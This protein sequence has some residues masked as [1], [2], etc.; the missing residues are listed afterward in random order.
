MSSLRPLLS[1]SFG[2]DARSLALLRMTAGVLF[3]LVRLVNLPQAVRLFSDHGCLTRA[4]LWAAGGHYSESFSLFL[5][6]GHPTGILLLYAF[7][8]VCGVALTVGYHTRWATF[9]CWFCDMSLYHRNPYIN[10]ASDNELQL[11]LLWGFF[12]P[13]GQLWS[14]DAR[15]STPPES[16]KPYLQ[17][18]TAAWRLQ[19]MA[20]YMGAALIKNTHHW[21]DGSAVEISLQSDFWSSYLGN[22]LCDWALGF[23]GLLSSVTESVLWIEFF[24]PLLIIAPLWQLQ[25][26]ALLSLAAMHILFGLCLNLETFSTVACSLMVGFLPAAAWER[27]RWLEISLNRLFA[28]PEKTPTSVHWGAPSAFMSALASWAAVCM[29]WGNLQAVGWAPV[30]LNERASHALRQLHLRQGWGMFVPPPYRGGWYLFRGQT[31]AGRWVNLLSWEAQDWVGPVESTSEALP[32]SRFYLLFNARLQAP[33]ASTHQHQR[34]AYNLRR[35]WERSHP[36][37]LDRICR[38]ELYR[39]TR[40]YVAGVGFGKPKQA[41]AYAG[42]A[43]DPY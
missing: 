8:L 11:C 17:V 31:R 28:A 21:F 35:L 14:L 34:L 16:K 41:Q 36:E 9:F 32:S 13:W 33:P 1:V 2:L 30:P 12:T 22:Q 42:P 5:S 4:Q 37:E 20:I 40:D 27:L 29:V 19:L 25:A 15:S 7:A 38:V 24:L 26:L 10:P 18:A 6:V 23:P 3:L 39:F 43:L